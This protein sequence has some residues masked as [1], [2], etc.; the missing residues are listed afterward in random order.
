MYSSLEMSSADWFSF[1]KFLIFSV[2]FLDFLFL[3]F[4]SIFF[5]GIFIFPD[6]LNLWFIF[7]FVLFFFF[8]NSS[9]W[10]ISLSCWIS[11]QTDSMRTSATLSHLYALTRQHAPNMRTAQP[12]ALRIAIGQLWWVSW[13]LGNMVGWTS[14]IAISCHARLSL[15][16]INGHNDIKAYDLVSLMRRCTL[17]K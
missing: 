4:V 8:G 1:V 15:L 10:W 11:L 9:S 12:C 7:C 2:L 14:L 6:I 16:V 5:V 13:V 17:I 3:H